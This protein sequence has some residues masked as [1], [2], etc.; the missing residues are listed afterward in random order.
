[1]FAVS[2]TFVIVIFTVL[3]QAFPSGVT[4]QNFTRET[5]ASREYFYI[6]GGYVETATGHL[7]SDQM[8]VE[9]LL[10][11]KPCQP[12]PLIFIHGQGQSGTNWLNKPDGGSG[13]ASYFLNQGYIVY[14]VD[15]TER[16]RSPWNPT[17]N[18]TLTTYTAEYIEMRMTASQDF[19]IWP[20]AILHTQWN[21]TGLMGDP[22]F[23]AF[24]SSN[25]EFQSNTVIQQQNMQAAGSA[26]LHKTGPAILAAH[27]QGGL[28]PWV[29]A[30]SVPDLVKGIIGLEPSGPPFRDAV[31]SSTPAR[32]WG[33]TDIPLTYSSINTN[34]TTPLQTKSIPNNSTG[35]DNCTVQAD[36]ARELV[37]LKKIPVVVMTSESGY[38][39]VYDGCTVSFLQQAGVHAEW[40]RLGE[41]GIHGNGHL[42]FLEK[43]SDEIA[44]VL[45]E[46]IRKNVT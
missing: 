37:N 19:N 46:W 17:G 22:I 14:I 20:Q 38:H 44:G 32:S 39:D 16:A 36:P 29:I 41:V 4:A 6:G 35:L 3:S 10:P 42:F 28:M 1:M 18:T 43:N 11:P 12:Y 23:D 40:L 21:G 9:K 34:S 33:L 25:V 8:Y 31:F 7:Y 2:I 27:S 15:Q 5:F 45:D 30:D 24:Y 13:W 26:L